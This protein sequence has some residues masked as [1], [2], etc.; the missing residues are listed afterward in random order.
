MC[1]AGLRGAVR[2]RQV[3]QL[4]QAQTLAVVCRTQFNVT[5]TSN[6]QAEP[7]F[8][9]TGQVIGELSS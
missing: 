7:H 2:S 9:A 8:K 4:M 6:S 1:P 3:H 5:D